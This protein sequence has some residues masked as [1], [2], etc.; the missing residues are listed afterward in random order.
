L[1]RP[2]I[3]KSTSGI[4]F[5]LVGLDLYSY[6]VHE[7]LVSLALFSLAFLLLALIVLTAILLWWASEQIASKTRPASRRV[8]AFSRRVI[9]THARS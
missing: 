9:A 2:N 4:V 1:R 3:I 7:L 8:I 6:Y 5:V